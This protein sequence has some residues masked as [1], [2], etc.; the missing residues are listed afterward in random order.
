MVAEHT[1][2]WEYGYLE[3]KPTGK[4]YPARRCPCGAHAIWHSG[5]DGIEPYDV[6]KGEFVPG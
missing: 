6:W 3:Y 2:I 5:D 4:I 1:H